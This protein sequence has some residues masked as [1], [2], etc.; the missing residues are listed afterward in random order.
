M[1]FPIQDRL[2]NIGTS[3]LFHGHDD[4]SNPKTSNYVDL[5]RNNSARDVPGSCDETHQ[6]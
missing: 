4:L 2:A 5:P 6:T 1:L 3:A